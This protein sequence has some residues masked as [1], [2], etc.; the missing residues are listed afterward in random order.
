[1][2]TI[3]S[4]DLKL[5]IMATGENAGTWGSIT[6]TNLYLLQQAIGGYEAISIAG[7]AQTTALTMSNGAISNARNA[8]IKLTGTITG[9]QVVTIPTAIEKTYIVSNGTTGA[10]TVEFKQAGGTGVTFAAADK[11]TKILF[12][13]GTNIVD[14]GDTTPI[15][16]QINDTNVNE[17]IKFTT[18][19]SAV[20][21]FTI[22]N[23]ATANA[24]EI[25]AT[26]SDTNIDLKI[27]PKGSGKIN[28]DGIKFPN[29]DGSSGQFLKTDGS[30]SLSFADSGL[31]WQ[32]V[33]TTSTITVVAGR[34]YF[35]NTTSNACTVT[36]PSGTPT[37]GAQVQLVDYAGTFD[38]NACVIN[39]NGNKLEG[40][41]GN[42]QLGGE[43]E[44]VILT[45]IDATQGWLATSGINEG[46]DAL[47]PVPYS[48]D[49]LVIAGGASGGSE[50][51]GGGGAGGYRTSTQNV[52]IGTVIT[53]T[54]GNGGAVPGTNA[55]GLNG[56]DSSISGSGLTT[57]TSS[58]GGGGSS[59]A[60]GGG[61]G[62]SGGG[63]APSVTSGL[64]GNSP[65]T[66]PSQGN[67]GGNG[68][69]RTQG[70]AGTGNES[71][72][73]GG[74]AGA[75]GNNSSSFTGA[76]GGAG[77]ASS[78]TGSSVTRAGGG[79]GGSNG[80]DSS[81]VGVGGSGGTGGG[82][83]GGGGT[84]PYTGTAGTANTGSGGGGSG[85]NGGSASGAGGKGVVILSM[86][87]ANY[88]GTTTG[89]PTVATGVSGKTV[90]TFTG[91]G[92]YTG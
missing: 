89:S 18:T 50:D 83:A 29:A 2:A 56:S 80:V 69:T 1:M 34:A 37:A 53:V 30:G 35:I 24:P 49:F 59:D 92:S 21:E 31:A 51:G 47:G 46:T 7:G 78:I 20:N 87:D 86:P 82:G 57:I 48:V 60:I 17:Q 36:L 81:P 9:N 40:G 3:Y 88:T 14:T 70:A 90:L 19:A 15:I 85:G 42:L 13:D 4:S 71:G 12:A 61:S 10:F 41:T 43:R 26:G 55:R 79:G 66:S 65:S 84:P 76:A 6:N 52:A 28:L 22:T 5:S 67:N 74:G 64:S 63:G 44:G 62:G 33:V 58:G 23:A 68:F 75:V 54:V 11:S 72:G 45:Y 77:S 73:G 91:S 39:P 25:S 27:T 8:V 16:T 38:T 32:S